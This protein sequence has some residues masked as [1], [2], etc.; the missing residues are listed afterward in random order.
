MQ[1][2]SD[3]D[4]S[5]ESDDLLQENNM[6]VAAQDLEDDT[7]RGEDVHANN[8]YVESIDFHHGE[9]EDD[10]WVNPTNVEHIT[11]EFNMSLALRI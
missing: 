2:N 9:F 5:N 8:K 1:E 4:E 10:D 7:Y 3:E 6:Q 11:F